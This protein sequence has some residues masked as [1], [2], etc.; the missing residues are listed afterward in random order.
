MGKGKYEQSRF[1]FSRQL[2][3]LPC[4]LSL[5]VFIS[6]W[7]WRILAVL[8][9]GNECWSKYKAMSPVM[10]DWWLISTLVKLSLVHCFCRGNWIGM[11]PYEHGR[12][13][14][15]CPPSYGGGCR[16]NLCYK[17]EK[18]QMFFIQD[19]TFNSFTNFNPIGLSLCRLSA[20]RHRGY[21][22]GGEASGSTTTSYHCQTCSQT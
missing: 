20:L 3:R 6:L 21:E 4:E 9:M 12:P 10:P 13:C 22:R 1:L 17:G 14:S 19:V 2:T 15:Q 8:T 16:N 18:T 11:A 5:P 7:D